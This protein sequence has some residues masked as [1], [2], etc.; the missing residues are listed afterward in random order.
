[1]L[2]PDEGSDDSIASIQTTVNQTVDESTSTTKVSAPLKIAQPQLAPLK[3]A[4]KEKVKNS[5]KKQKAVNE[6]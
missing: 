2:S 4:P 3:I 6:N 1:M 5:G